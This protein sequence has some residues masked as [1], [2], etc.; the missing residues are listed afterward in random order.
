MLTNERQHAVEAARVEH[1][2]RFAS[3]DK[4]QHLENTHTHKPVT[5]LKIN[6]GAQMLYLNALFGQV[7][8][9]A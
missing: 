3:A 2:T 7:L 4:L 5:T 9:C 8:A 1:G 6:V